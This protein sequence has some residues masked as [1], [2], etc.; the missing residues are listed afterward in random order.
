M[1]EISTDLGIDLSR[2][3]V[4]DEDEDDDEEEEAIVPVMKA[5]REGLWRD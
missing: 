4:S 3:I 2:D 5:E 1:E